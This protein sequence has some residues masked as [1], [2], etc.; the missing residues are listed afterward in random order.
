MD[1]KH[2]IL[3]RFNLPFDPQS[4][5]HIQPDWL[6][7]RFRL[8]EAYCL[9]SIV[10]QT[11]QHFDW[12]IFVSDQTPEVYLQRLQQLTLAYGNIHIELCPYYQNFND[13]YKSMGE[14]YIG[15]ND[16]LLSTR[17][18][19]DDMLAANYVEILHNHIST[20]TPC[21]VIIT[22]TRGIQWFEQ[23]NIAFAV[24]YNKNHFL[25]F[26]E[27]KPTIQTS[28]GA[29]HTLIH[30][31]DLLALDEP[32]MWCEIVH[33]SNLCNSYVPKYR[34]SLTYSTTA[35]P[36]HVEANKAHQC[37]FL[38]SEH[39]KFRYHQFMRLLQKLA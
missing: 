36:I 28:L 22:F 1:Y 23:N 10:G 21:P 27:K 6:D 14:K 2:L 12:V 15:E 7:E 17:I 13:L 29:D 4:H 35:F 31:K 26:W 24:E 8:F 39:I 19:N 34:Y 25:N 5:I 30:T 37:L 32:D 38:L 11:C 18:D 9:P 16:F 20:S 33:S 3:T